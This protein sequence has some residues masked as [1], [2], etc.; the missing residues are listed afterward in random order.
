[1]DIG[2]CAGAQVQLEVVGR[3]LRKIE[4]ACPTRHCQ[5]DSLIE[6]EICLHWIN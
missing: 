2:D 1:V 3:L 4:I 6:D 5:I